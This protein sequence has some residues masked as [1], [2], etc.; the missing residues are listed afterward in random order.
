MTQHPVYAAIVSGPRFM[1]YKFLY[2][3]GDL[4]EAVVPELG[5][6]VNAHLYWGAV[7]ICSFLE[8]IK[9]RIE[10]YFCFE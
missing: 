5:L 4:E 10:G 1:F 3:T 2:E 6:W 7:N 8:I 9:W